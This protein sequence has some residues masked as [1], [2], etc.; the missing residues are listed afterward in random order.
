[1]KNLYSR[2]KGFA[3]VSPCLKISS[4]FFPSMVCTATPLF[5]SLPQDN[6]PN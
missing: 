5:S 3:L 1:V 2:D 6:A 4:A